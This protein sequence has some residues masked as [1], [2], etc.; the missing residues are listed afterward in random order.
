MVDD[1]NEK[2][3]KYI[4]I[5]GGIIELFNLA[6]E[7]VIHMQDCVQN[8]W[9]MEPVP[10]QV[11]LFWRNAPCKILCC[12]RVILSSIC[13]LRLLR[14]LGRSL[15]FLAKPAGL[16]AL[17]RQLIRHSRWLPSPPDPQNRPSSA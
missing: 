3:R 7:L 8:P 11:G 2:Y 10:R 15:N 12:T 5:H 9:Q 13:W 14:S 17:R 6:W 1:K 4:K 16:Q